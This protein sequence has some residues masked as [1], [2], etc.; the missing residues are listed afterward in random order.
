MD[1]TVWRSRNREYTYVFL[2]SDF[3]FEELPA[4][5]REAFGQPEPVI[6]LVLSP[7]R[8]LANEDINVVMHNLEAQGFHL[9]LPPREDPSGWLDIKPTARTLL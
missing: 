4:S 5:L 1:C 2:R 3:P 8:Q 6:D 7:E 9:Q